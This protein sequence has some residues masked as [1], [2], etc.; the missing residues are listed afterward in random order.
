MSPRNTSII[1]KVIAISLLSASPALANHSTFSVIMIEYGKVTLEA[2][3][4]ADSALNLEMEAR[5]GNEANDVTYTGDRHTFTSVGVPAT[6]EVNFQPGTF[7]RGEP[8]IVALTEDLV[9]TDCNF[10]GE[11][12][13]VTI[14]FA[15]MAPVPTLSGYASIALVLTLMLLGGSVIRRRRA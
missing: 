8:I 11:G 14:D 2:R 13:I 4:T 7:S 15:P 10:G 9:S 6:L 12:Y 5:V 1:L 3:A